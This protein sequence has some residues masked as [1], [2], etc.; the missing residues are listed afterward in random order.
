MKVLVTAGATWVKVDDAR[1]LTNKFTG[2]TGL[3]LAQALKKQGHKVTLIIN[4]HC[5]G[6]IKGI[7]TIYYRYLDEFIK[8]VDKA[9]K[10]ESFGMIIHTAAVSDYKLKSAFKGKI[11]SNKKELVL[12]LTP[13]EKVI[14]RMRRL[15]K[16][17][18]IVQFKLEAKTRSL[19]SKAYKSLKSNKSNYVVA[20]SLEDLKKGYKAFLIDKDKNITAIGSK[21]A[22]S[23]ILSGALSRTVL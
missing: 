23:E 18:L 11:P 9:L 2:K 6:E 20:N 13:S 17:A 22:L 12:K 1:I 10:R 21:K 8:A 15:A 5:I 14:K 4:P 19:C 16:N 7:K 3:F